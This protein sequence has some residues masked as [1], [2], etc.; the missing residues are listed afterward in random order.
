MSDTSSKRTLTNTEYATVLSAI[1]MLLPIVGSA[2]FATEGAETVSLPAKTEE[3]SVKQLHVALV[4]SAAALSAKVAE[5]ERDV[6]AQI[7]KG[8][9]GL[10][11]A[12]RM[13]RVQG[14][15]KI[16]NVVAELPAEGMV[17]EI[18]LAKLGDEAKVPTDTR[19]KLSDAMAFCP[20]GLNEAQFVKLAHEM[21][22]KF[23]KGQAKDGIKTFLVPISP[24][25]VTKTLAALRAPKVEESAEIG[26]EVELPS[27]G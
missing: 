18:V 6:K 20:K 21:S 10:F 16:A 5:E 2:A 27:N 22:Y 4:R 23:P 12:A 25:Y 26:T 3:C 8:I 17:R 19:V 14:Y 24:E 13:A 11:D 1:G 9:D 15:L 7:K